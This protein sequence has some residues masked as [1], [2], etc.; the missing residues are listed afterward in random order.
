M[1]T[2]PRSTQELAGAAAVRLYGHPV[3]IWV[4]MLGRGAWRARVIRSD[5]KVTMCVG[6][7]EATHEQALHELRTKLERMVSVAGRGR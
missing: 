2:A 1:S 7:L 4:A 6:P 3:G 5:N